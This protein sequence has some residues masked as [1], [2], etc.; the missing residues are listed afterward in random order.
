MDPLNRC[1]VLRVPIYFTPAVSRKLN[2]V[3]EFHSPAPPKSR[4]PWG[5]QG[6]SQARLKLRCHVLAA[7]VIYSIAR[8]VADR[9]DDGPSSFEEGTAIATSFG[10]L[11]VLRLSAAHTQPLNE[12]KALNSK[13]Y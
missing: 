13:P 5:F 10:C 2:A 4:D 6:A 3:Q 8:N 9:V 12:A 11:C 1:H 7:R